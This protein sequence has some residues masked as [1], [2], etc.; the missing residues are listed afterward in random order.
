MDAQIIE[1]LKRINNGR[2]VGAKKK[3]A[4]ILG[5]SETTVG[6]WCN[7]INLPT[8]DNISKISKALKVKE[9][10]LQ[11][12]FEVQV[13][14]NNTNSFNNGSREME[15]LKKE[16]QLKNKEIELLKKEIQLLKK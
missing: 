5:V 3:L 16:L 1:F 2:V 4:E 14:S 6:K 9:D 10:Y 15:L 11:K 7:K 12:I 8:V 13:N